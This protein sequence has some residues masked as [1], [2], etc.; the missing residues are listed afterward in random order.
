MRHTVSERDVHP[1][2]VMCILRH[3]TWPPEEPFAAEVGAHRSLKS[4]LDGPTRTVTCR[5]AFRP[6]P[7]RMPRSVGVAVR[8]RCHRRTP[9]LYFW[10]DYA[11]EY[12]CGGPIWSDARA[13]RQAGY[14]E[15]SDLIALSIFSVIR[16]EIP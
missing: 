12:P 1:R 15:L 11:L 4:V 13:A 7:L 14:D 5:V 8:L 16:R 6:M 9:R 10:A 2:E 3:V